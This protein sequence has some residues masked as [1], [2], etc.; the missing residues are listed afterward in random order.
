MTEM[1]RVPSSGAID[2]TDWG[3]ADEHPKRAIYLTKLMREQFQEHPPD[4]DLPFEYSQGHGDGRHG[5]AVTDPLTL[6]LDIPLGETD[7]EGPLWSCTL[8]AII[9][10]LIANSGQ[11]DEDTKAIFLVI[12][13]ALRTLA[14]RLVAAASES[15]EQKQEAS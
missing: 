2:F 8:G 15:R 7:G 13:E 3:F 10:E 11:P 14:D 1:T 4:L 5:P 9:D 6:Y 12:G